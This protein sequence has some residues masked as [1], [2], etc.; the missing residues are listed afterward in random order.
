MKI[1]ERRIIPMKAIFDFTRTF[2][3][4]VIDEHGVDY[5]DFLPGYPRTEPGDWQDSDLSAWSHQ[6]YVVGGLLHSHLENVASLAEREASDSQIVWKVY[7][8]DMSLLHVVSAPTCGTC[9]T[10]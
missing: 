10:M 9:G 7:R 2:L 1:H 8:G 4:G 3:M 5:L 6:S